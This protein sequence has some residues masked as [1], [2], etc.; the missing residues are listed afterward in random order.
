[1]PT[2]NKSAL[3]PSPSRLEHGDSPYVS[4]FPD[5]HNPSPESH[6]PAQATYC[7]EAWF[8]NAFLR[9]SSAYA[10][11]QIDQML[12]NAYTWATAG[13]GCTIWHN[14]TFSGPDNAIDPIKFAKLAIE[15]VEALEGLNEELL[16]EAILRSAYNHI[17]VEG[18][19]LGAVEE[20]MDLDDNEE[21]E[22]EEV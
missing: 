6:D 9:G 20:P 22:E 8:L 2:T 14:A 15:V 3:A 17:R 10:K 19:G 13:A 12:K 16:E 1:M 4:G 11:K 7:L 21:E 18:A 5:L